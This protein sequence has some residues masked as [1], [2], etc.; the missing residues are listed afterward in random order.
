MTRFQIPDIRDF[1]K[2]LFLGDSFDF[3]LVSRASFVTGTAVTLDG[4]LHKGYF[5][6]AQWRS[7]SSTTWLPG[8]S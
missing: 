8:P 5:T 7:L 6:D 4:A 1:T 3:F 2:K